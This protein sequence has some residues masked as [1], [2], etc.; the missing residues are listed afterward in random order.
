MVFFHRAKYRQG[1]GME[2]LGIWRIAVD[3]TGLQQIMARPAEPALGLVLSGIT[4]DGRGLVWGR[5]GLEGASVEILDLATG[6]QRALPCC[7]AHVEAWRFGRPRALV[8]RHGGNPPDSSL[9]LWD[10][11]DPANETVLFGPNKMVT[12]AAWEPEGKHLVAAIGTSYMG[13]SLSILDTSGQVVSTLPGTTAAFRPRWEA[14]GI[15]YE[16]WEER[17][18][19]KGRF[20]EPREIRMISPSRG[21]P[22]TLFRSDHGPRLGPVVIPG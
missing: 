3:G 4:P 12:G 9:V 1:A 6:A 17:T 20:Y 16:H 10:D 19:T 15:M 11:L 18:T 8:T 2:E 13:Q 21:T 5:S 22:V 14:P 7:L